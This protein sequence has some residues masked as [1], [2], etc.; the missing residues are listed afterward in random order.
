LEPSSG[1]AR[2]GVYCSSQRT[3][4]VT[5]QAREQLLYETTCVLD[6]ETVLDTIVSIPADTAETDLTLTIWEDSH[7]LLW[8]TPLART[9][10][11]VPVPA[12][13]AK[14]PSELDSNEALFLN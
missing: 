11:D 8:Y 3:V 1:A 13:P 7:R 5:L 2:I 6:P 4:R 9:G 12:T 14:S 10:N